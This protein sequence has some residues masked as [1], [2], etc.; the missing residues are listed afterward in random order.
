MHNL[1]LCKFCTTNVLFSGFDNI[2]FYNFLLLIIRI[3][4]CSC[5]DLLIC[6]WCLGCG[7]GWKGIVGSL[8]GLKVMEISFESRLDFKS[9]S[10]CLLIFVSTNLVSS[11]LIG[12]F[13]C[14]FLGSF[15]HLWALLFYALVHFFIIFNV[16]LVSHQSKKLQ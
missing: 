9:L 4:S 10:G 3:C 13:S 7:L 11:F 6:F 5:R 12:L 15:H 8:E 16:S 1:R 14:N 2:F